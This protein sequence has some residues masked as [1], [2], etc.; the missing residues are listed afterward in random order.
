MRLNIY[1]PTQ[2]SDAFSCPSQSVAS[3]IP[4]KHEVILTS[5]HPVPHLRTFRTHTASLK[6][7]WRWQLLLSTSLMVARGWASPGL[8]ELAV[9]PALTEGD[10]WKC[11]LNHVTSPSSHS[12]VRIKAEVLWGLHDVNVYVPTVTSVH[13]PCSFTQPSHKDFLQ[14]PGHTRQACGSEPWIGVLTAPNVPPSHTGTQNQI[15]TGLTY[16]LCLT[17]DPSNQES[18][19]EFFLEIFTL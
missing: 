14:F 3:L 17:E 10:L 1:S 19:S 18:Y 5:P 2:A 8:P 16:T 13:N 9:F 15:L 6:T 12:A 11:N 4:L 7:I